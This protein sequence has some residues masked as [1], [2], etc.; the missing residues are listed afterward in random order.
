MARPS[1]TLFIS[2]WENS[3]SLAAHVATD[4]GEHVIKVRNN[5][6][7]PRVLINEWVGTSIAAELGVLV[8]DFAIVNVPEQLEIPLRPG[9]IAEPGPAFG[10]RFEEGQPWAGKS[11]VSAVANDDAFSRLVVLDT[12]LLNVDRYSISR[13]RVRKKPENLW[14][15]VEEAP[16]GKFLLKAI[17]EG[18]CFGGTGWGASD[19]RRI[20]SIKHP[21][22][23]GLFPEFENRLQ[24]EE[25]VRT[26][27]RASS[28]T[29]ARLKAI[30]D[31]VPGEWGL[32]RAEAEA[33]LEFLLDRARYLRT[34]LPGK[35][36][37]QR[38]LEP[39][40]E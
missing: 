20:D 23:F 36:W 11:S 32:S 14:L 21:A 19:L 24:R 39:K 3:S 34:E 7:G 25:V 12:W 30:I 17:D 9:L 2:V 1:A 40:A 35:I 18:H 15:S 22:I 13:N 27:E 26:L 5:P 31:Q 33:L 37:P 8:P 29:R 38:D 4:Q 10:S 28:I 16:P 6:E